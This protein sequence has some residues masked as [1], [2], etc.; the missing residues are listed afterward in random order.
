MLIA[1]PAIAA[2]PPL[3]VEISRIAF[4]SCLRQDKPAPILDAIA[5]TKPD[6]FIWLGDNIYGDSD[7]PK[8]M[9]A[10]YDTLAAIPG[11]QKLRQQ[12]PFLYVWDDHDY[13]KNDA[14]VE[15]AFKEQNKTVM[16]D[17]FGE[18]KDSERRK[19]DGNYDSK[20][21][22]PTGRRVQFLLLDTRSF[23]SPLKQE[24]RDKVKW[25][26]PN[27]DEGATVLGDAQWKW[28]EEELKQPA[29]VRVV[30]S[31][32]QVIPTEHRFE[33]WANFPKERERLLKLLEPFS[34]SLLIIS[35]DRHHGSVHH[36][37]GLGTSEVTASALNQPG[38][39]TQQDINSATS[40]EPPIGKPN[41]GWMEIDWSKPNGSRL[42]FGLK[43]FEA[44]P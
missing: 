41:Y 33:K 1:S 26:V 2:D 23:R 38:T 16:L 37:A 15:Y 19:R 36:L 5:E 30:C 44:T 32:I 28:L 3:P 35:G 42:L 43:A 7:D 10:K 18:P 31:S 9:Q 6:V 25:N 34:G 39:P 24:V 8:V 29:E 12:S 27:T 4:G 17:F 21:I 14:G 11:F 13:G 22:G 20:I 40:R